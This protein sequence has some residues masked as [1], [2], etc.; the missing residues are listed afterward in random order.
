M[1]S[2]HALHFKFVLACP[3]L[4]SVSGC[5]IVEM[6][7]TWKQVQKKKSRGDRM[8]TSMDD[9]SLDEEE[10]MTM[11]IADDTTFTFPSYAYIRPSI[12]P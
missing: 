10:P 2:A 5:K 11:V 8:S 9:S 12:R 1:A 3:L 4:H 7:E 6:K